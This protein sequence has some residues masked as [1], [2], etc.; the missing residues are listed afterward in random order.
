MTLEPVPPTLPGVIDGLRRRVDSLER[1]PMPAPNRHLVDLVASIAVPFDG[2]WNVA[3]STPWFP[4]V[5]VTFTGLDVIAS[6]T[7]VADVDFALLGFDIRT[8]T[9]PAGEAR[10]RSMFTD[11]LTVTP[12][13]AVT[14]TITENGGASSLDA[15]TVIAR[16]VVVGDYRPSGG[17]IF[18]TTYVGVD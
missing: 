7:G 2:S 3:T 9:L 11:P 13:D 12:F 5:D 16:G 18:S 1:A 17:L 15:A 6:G 4:Q 10:V 14:F 8:V